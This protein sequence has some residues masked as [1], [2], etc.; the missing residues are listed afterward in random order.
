LKPKSSLKNAIVGYDS[1]SHNIL[2]VTVVFS[3]G[4]TSL[5]AIFKPMP[6]L[7]A[8]WNERSFLSVDQ[9]RFSDA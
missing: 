9:K 1:R 6:L 8:K 5:L 7:L 3:T 2:I 4:K